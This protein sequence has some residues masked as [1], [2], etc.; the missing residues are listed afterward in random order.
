[1]PVSDGRTYEDGL[2]DALAICRTTVDAMADSGRPALSGRVCST[3][4]ERKIVEGGPVIHVRVNAE[5][6]DRV[7][8][9]AAEK[10]QRDRDVQEERRT[11]EQARETELLAYFRD[12]EQTARRLRAEAE[13]AEK[14]RS[15]AY[16]AAA[17]ERRRLRREQ[18]S[19]AGKAGERLA[20]R[21]RLRCL[22]SVTPQ[23]QVWHTA[24]TRK[25]LDRLGKLGI[26]GGSTLAEVA[27]LEAN[28]VQQVWGWNASLADASLEALRQTLS[29]AGLWMVGDDPVDMRDDQ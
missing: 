26:L 27:V 7:I 21:L 18:L 17:S 29:C 20:E 8:A 28:D 4:I 11:R 16:A 15:D 24:P 14:D 2:R 22:W 12:R 19:A 25:T 1:M 5:C 9:A 10:A 23:T 3:L 13:K 6:D